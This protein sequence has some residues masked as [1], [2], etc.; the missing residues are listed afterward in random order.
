MLAAWFDAPEEEERTF[1]RRSE[2]PGLGPPS[3]AAAAPFRAAA[4]PRGPAL[5]RDAAPQNRG[6]APPGRP[7]GPVPEKFSA[8]VHYAPWPALDAPEQPAEQLA[9]QP[10]EQP[11][12]QPAVQPAAERAALR[13]AVAEAVAAS[14]LDFEEC[15]KEPEEC[16]PALDSPNSGEDPTV[17]LPSTLV[18]AVDAEPSDDED[19]TTGHYWASAEQDKLIGAAPPGGGGAAASAADPRG[20]SD[21]SALCLGAVRKYF[22][23]VFAY[24]PGVLSLTMREPGGFAMVLRLP[25]NADLD[26]AM[27]RILCSQHLFP[28]DFAIHQLRQTED[29]SLSFSVFVCDPEM[30]WHFPAGRCRRGEN[31]KWSHAPP[32]Q[33]KVT[34]HEA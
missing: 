23:A 29:I 21:R 7:P 6:A 32:I 18:E 2:R 22:L 28:A 33:F 9:E 16:D 30:C 25:T 24:L 11:S 13:A 15:E 14:A 19:P 26:E 17:W 4:A 31:C 8:F 20:G 12:E 5:L 10:S 1:L 3:R 27:H 34:L